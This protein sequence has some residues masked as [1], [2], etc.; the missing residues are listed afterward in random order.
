MIKNHAIKIFKKLCVIESN[1][2]YLE[3]DEVLMTY[4][5]RDKIYAKIHENYFIFYNFYNKPCLVSQST[6][7]YI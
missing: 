5:I 7:K 2:D 1:V 3:I 6:Y 4:V